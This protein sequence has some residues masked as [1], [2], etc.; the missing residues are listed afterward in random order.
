MGDNTPNITREGKA[1]VLTAPTGGGGKPAI[2]TKPLRG[3]GTLIIRTPAR[4]HHVEGFAGIRCEGD[5][6]AI[7]TR[8]EGTPTL[9]GDIQLISVEH[10]TRLDGSGRITLGCRDRVQYM[11]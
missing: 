11:D 6:S 9:H 2:L 1:T 8:L 10:I 7:I 5:G 4:L 3:S